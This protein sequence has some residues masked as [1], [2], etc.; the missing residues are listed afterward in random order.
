MGF[1]NEAISLGRVQE[2]GRTQLFGLCAI[3]VLANA[4]FEQAAEAWAR[5]SAYAV[6]N[7]LGVN[8]GL[9]L[10]VFAVVWLASKAA[11]GRADRTDYIIA[12]AALITCLAPEAD[13]ASLGATLLAGRM[14]LSS[15]GDTYLR[16]AGVVLLA[17]TI[18][19]FWTRMALLFVAQP[20]QNFDAWLVSLLGGVEVQGNV[21]SYASGEG[22]A[23]LARGCMSLAN[24][25]AALMVWLAAARL[26]RPEIRRS[27][28]GWAA[29]VMASVVALN[30][31]RIALVMQSRENYAVFH[32]GWGSDLFAALILIAA[33][34]IAAFSVRRELFD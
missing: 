12:G 5:G 21:L 13:V 14:A 24:A 32:G 30:T 17:I 25:S 3:V 19:V 23:F 9:W 31:A 34:A 18:N 10:A 29:V 4:L 2:F 26:I 20:L 16:A 33:L 27:D 15:R 8:W 22:S 11:P 7:G 6:A 1:T 28:L